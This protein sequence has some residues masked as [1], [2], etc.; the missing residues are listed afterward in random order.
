V[1]RRLHSQWLSMQ[2]YRALRSC[3]PSIPKDLDKVAA[4]WCAN[5]DTGTTETPLDPQSLPTLHPVRDYYP[6]EWITTPS[7]QAP[8]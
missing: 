5:L 1:L 2:I 4:M 6:I 8:N 7:A 3:V